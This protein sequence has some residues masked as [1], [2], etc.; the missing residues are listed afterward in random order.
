MVGVL[1]VNV[2]CDLNRKILTQR[3]RLI[4]R[5]IDFY[6][7]FLVI[8]GSSKRKPASSCHIDLNSNRRVRLLFNELLR[9]TGINDTKRG[10]AP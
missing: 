10:A 3:R 6:C 4:S 1:F 7:I 9:T 5:Y 8:K 2:S